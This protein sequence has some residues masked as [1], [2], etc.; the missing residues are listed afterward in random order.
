MLTLRSS[1]A[2]LTASCEVKKRMKGRKEEG[3][4]E[5]EKGGIYTWDEGGSLAQ[6]QSD[7]LSE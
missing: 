5:G 6:Y 2:G 4:S 1:R 7:S 3:K